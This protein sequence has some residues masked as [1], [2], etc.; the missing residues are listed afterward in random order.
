MIL[1]RRLKKCVQQVQEL[2]DRIKAMSNVIKNLE[3]CHNCGLFIGD[4][5][6][7]YVYKDT[8][9]CPA[10]YKLLNRKGKT[11]LKFLTVVFLLGTLAG[12]GLCGYEYYDGNADLGGYGLLGGAASLVL[13]IVTMVF[14]LT[15]KSAPAPSLRET[16]D[17]RDA[18]Q[19]TYRR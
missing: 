12:A 10:C 3:E 18:R 9:V 16:Y 6:I 1:R 2:S 14:R 5:V 8:C 15:R 19:S 17:P 11:V 7:P 13:L 4:N